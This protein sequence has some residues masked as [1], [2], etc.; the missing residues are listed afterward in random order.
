MNYLVEKLQEAQSKQVVMAKKLKGVEDNHKETATAVLFLHDEWAGVSKSLSEHTKILS[1]I[2]SNAQHPGGGPHV[3]AKKRKRTNDQ[4]KLHKKKK[5]TSI[6]K[7]S[8]SP[9]DDNNQ[10]PGGVTRRVLAGSRKRW[11]AEN[12]ASKSHKKKKIA[13]ESETSSSSDEDFASNMHSGAMTTGAEDESDTASSESEYNPTGGGEPRGFDTGP[14][15]KAF[16]RFTSYLATPA[17]KTKV[18][19]LVNGLLLN[20]AVPELSVTYLFRAIFFHSGMSTYYGYHDDVFLKGVFDSVDRLIFSRKPKTTDDPP[21]DFLVGDVASRMIHII[22]KMLEGDVVRGGGGASGGN[23]TFSCDSINI[24]ES[25]TMNLSHLCDSVREYLTTLGRE[26][27]QYLNEPEFFIFSPRS[28]FR[29]EYDNWCTLFKILDVVD[30]ALQKSPIN[31]GG[32]NA[33]ARYLT[34]CLKLKFHHSLTFFDWV[35]LRAD[36]GTYRP[37]GKGKRRRRKRSQGRGAREF[38]LTYAKY[39]NLVTQLIQ[40]F[41]S[42][43]R[44][45]KAR[46]FDHYRCD[47]D[48][49]QVSAWDFDSNGDLLA[50]VE[51]Q[52]D[53]VSSIHCLNVFDILQAQG[54]KDATLSFTDLLH[55]LLPL[56]VG[57]HHVDSGTELNKV[58][59]MPYVQAVVWSNLN[60]LN[61]NVEAKEMVVDFTPG[62]NFPEEL[63]AQKLS[64]VTKREEARQCLEGQMKGQMNEKCNSK[65]N[66]TLEFLQPLEHLL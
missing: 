16:I 2:A 55:I 49:V 29:P 35:N 23:L 8:D 26:I 6:S 11:G 51:K 44:I 63:D 54:T 12:V 60:N 50:Y 21:L 56:L 10:P 4:S 48:V 15:E 59:F 45:F 37:K 18:T 22:G 57:D 28:P 39:Y 3:A 34:E 32:E 14:E 61:Y 40:S 42:H 62:A 52:K 5:T 9:G 53:H 27:S 17:A 20:T 24:R 30:Q 7:T 38:Q 31:E 36:L 46:M 47:A 64:S 25:N 1:T 41:Q 43:G 33:V 58:M 19:A 13:D 65:D 66:P